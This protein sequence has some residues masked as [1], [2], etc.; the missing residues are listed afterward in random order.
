MRLRCWVPQLSGDWPGLRKSMIGGWPGPGTLLYLGL[1][2]A[3][4]SFLFLVSIFTVVTSG[5][6]A[7]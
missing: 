4:S 5:A 7:V 1:S 2:L 6:C 3:L